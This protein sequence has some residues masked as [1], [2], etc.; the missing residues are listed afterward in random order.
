MSAGADAR[1]AA[2][3]TAGRALLED[4]L[5]RV[6][7]AYSDVAA[8]EEHVDGLATML[9]VCVTDRVCCVLIIYIEQVYS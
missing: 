1:R 3:P 9:E 5:A 4:S 7:S 8:A 6:E 2:S